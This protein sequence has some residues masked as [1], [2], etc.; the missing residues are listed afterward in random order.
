MASA[1]HPKSQYPPNELR[2]GT[3]LIGWLGRV[4]GTVVGGKQLVAVTGTLLTL[5]VIGHLVGNLKI[6]AGQASINEYAQFLK[7]LG[8]LLWIARIGLLTLFVVHI[9]LGIWVKRRSAQARPVGYAYSNTV[10][11]SVASRIM[12]TTGLVVGAFVLFHLAH[13]TLGWVKGTE[14]TVPYA[15]DKDSANKVA[16]TGSALNEYTSAPE[17]LDRIMKEHDL[18][19]G[20]TVTVNY[21]D[22][23]DSA[24]LHDVYTMG[25]SGFRHPLISGLYILAM[26]IFFFHLKHGIASAAQT[27]GLNT[28]RLNRWWKVI[29]LAV[30]LFI[31]VG[32]ISIPVTILLGGLEPNPDVA[33]TLEAYFS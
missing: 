3:G 6:Y 17:K 21:L 32:N 24:G 26:L 33:L 10:Q 13:Y 27:L 15:T 9:S 25:I 18:S 4:T 29:T 1:I 28:P 2:E 7:D 19:P 31:V 12:L 5:W 8:P 20:D 14:I 11:A 30:A 16:L 23:R 22:L